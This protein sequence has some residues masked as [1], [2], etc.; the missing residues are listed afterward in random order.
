MLGMSWEVAVAEN[1]IP[2]LTAQFASHSEAN[3][4]AL[5]FANVTLWGDIVLSLFL[6]LN[7]PF[8]YGSDNV[9]Q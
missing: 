6:Y 9:V 3:I 4:L 1:R 7:L 8:S 5:L 2:K